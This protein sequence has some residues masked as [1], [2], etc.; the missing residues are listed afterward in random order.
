MKLKEGKYIITSVENAGGVY[1]DLWLNTMRLD[2]DP[3]ARVG[4]VLFNGIATECGLGGD[5]LNYGMVGLEIDVFDES[6]VRG[7]KL[8]RR[9]FLDWAAIACVPDVTETHRTTERC[10]CRFC[11]KSRWE[12]LTQ[13]ETATRNKAINEAV[14]AADRSIVEAPTHEGYE[15]LE[16]IKKAIERLKRDP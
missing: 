10:M 16:N 1:Y 4:Q 8:S 7:F 12:F 6:I 15:M 5:V 11:E 9:G 2:R 3:D 13:R 14:R